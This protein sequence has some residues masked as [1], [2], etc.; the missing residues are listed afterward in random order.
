V[1]LASAAAMPFFF[2]EGFF[3]FLAG[4]D[5]TTEAGSIDWS[6]STLSARCRLPPRWV[7][8]RLDILYVIWSL[9]MSG[10]TLILRFLFTMM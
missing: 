3:C 7:S 5:R 9:V 6:G 4:D 2:G 8:L 10:L 1:T